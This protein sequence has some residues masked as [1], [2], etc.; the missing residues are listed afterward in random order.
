[1]LLKIKKFYIQNLTKRSNTRYHLL[2]VLRVFATDLETILNTEC[3]CCPQNKKI[4]DKLIP[5]EKYNS[6]SYIK[7]S[8]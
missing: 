4:T 5:N 1:M 6:Y 2:V 3:G 7:L 8:L